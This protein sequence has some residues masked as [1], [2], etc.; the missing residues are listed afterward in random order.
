MAITVTEYRSGMVKKIDFAYTALTTGSTS[1]STA[2]EYDGEIIRV[3][4][5]NTKLTNGTIRLLDEDSNDILMGAGTL[6]TGTAYFEPTT[7]GALQLGG[8]FNSALTLEHTVYP[9]TGA[10]HVYV[11]VR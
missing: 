4:A 6:T 7:G 3:V 1:G 8:I 10:G 5:V 2:Y 11:Y 9:T